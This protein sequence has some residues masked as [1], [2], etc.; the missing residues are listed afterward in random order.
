MAL[1]EDVKGIIVSSNGEYR[2]FG[3]HKMVNVSELTD[4][5]Y[6]DESFNI[7]IADS[8]WFKKSN[9]PYDKNKSLRGQIFDLTKYGFSIILN[10]NSKSD[11]GDTYIYTV[12]CPYNMSDNTKEFFSGIYEEFNELIKKDDALFFGE[13]YLEGEYIWDDS[14]YSIDDFYEKMNISRNSKQM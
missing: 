6:H 8:E 5:N 2:T 7:D 11:I 14:A 12:Q 9:C 3:I 4:E 13:P 1:I 10:G